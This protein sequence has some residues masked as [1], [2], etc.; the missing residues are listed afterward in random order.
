MTIYPFKAYNTY[1][2]GTWT[3]DILIHK[4]SVK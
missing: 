2:N 1:L 4:K 3:M